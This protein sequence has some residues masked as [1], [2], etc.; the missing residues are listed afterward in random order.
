VDNDTRISKLRTYL[1]D[2]ID[3]LTKNTKYQ[4]NADMLSTN[5]GD[6]SLDRIPSESTITKWITGLTIKRDVYSL[7]S[8]MAYSQDM[9]NNLEN[10]GFFEKFEEKITENNREG[11]LPEI[12]GIQKV[13]CLNTGTMNNAN[14]NTAE[15]DIQIQITYRKEE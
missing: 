11:I 8:R 4:I 6:Y 3:D 10:I 1:L 5:V 9:I 2:V 15:F 12:D 7:R 13:E 14:T